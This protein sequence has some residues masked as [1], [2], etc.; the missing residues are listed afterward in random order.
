MTLNA[1]RP[2]AGKLKG[3]ENLM[4]VIAMEKILLDRLLIRKELRL[5]QIEKKLKEQSEKLKESK[6]KLKNYQ[7]LA[8]LRT[9]QTISKACGVF[10]LLMF[11]IGRNGKDRNIRKNTGKEYLEKNYSWM[12]GKDKSIKTIDYGLIIIVILTIIPDWMKIVPVSFSV[13]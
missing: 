3:S 5:I 10:H 13:M 2:E 12:V 11:G 4:T 8:G 7:S 1:H 6:V 9:F